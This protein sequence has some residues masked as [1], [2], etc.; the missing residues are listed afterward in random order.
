MDNLKKTNSRDLLKKQ[1]KNPLFKKEYEALEKEFT[2]AKEVISLRK[3]ANITQKELADLSGTSQPAIA[4]LESGEYHNLSLTFLRRVGKV[5][6]VVPEIRF[7][8]TT[9]T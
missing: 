7:R 3:K 9:A 5:L 4:R 2:I 1:L 6:G 8:K